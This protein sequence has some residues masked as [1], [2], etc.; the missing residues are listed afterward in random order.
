MVLYEVLLLG[1]KVLVHLC[2]DLLL[3]LRVVVAHHCACHVLPVFGHLVL[4]LGRGLLVVLIALLR[5]LL[6]E[7]IIFLGLAVLLVVRLIVVLLRL[8]LILRGQRLVVVIAPTLVV[9]VEVDAVIAVHADV[10][11]VVGHVLGVAHIG[12]RLGLQPV[13]ACPILPAILVVPASVVG[14]VVR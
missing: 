11:V 1:K 13:V 12:G 14:Q 4:H 8:L 5:V 6:I 10:G 9:R 3:E 7:E 2:Q